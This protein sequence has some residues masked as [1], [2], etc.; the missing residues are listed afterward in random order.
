MKTKGTYILVLALDEAC[1]VEVGALGALCF[2]PGIYA[3]VGSALGPGGLPARLARHRRT[4]KTLH[5]HIDYL[6]AHARLVEIWQQRGTERRE[7]AWA[8]TLA[9]APGGHAV[10]GFGASDCACCA[11]L[12]RF[13]HLSALRA[14]CAALHIEAS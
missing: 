7:C 10:A 5:W 11:H 9:A 2:V 8:Q 12:F 1:T 14:V 4:H 13:P 6:R 3:Y